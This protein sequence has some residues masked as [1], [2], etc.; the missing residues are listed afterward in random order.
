MTDD[1]KI[2]DGKIRSHGK[3]LTLPAVVRI[4]NAHKRVVQTHQEVLIEANEERDMAL[5]EEFGDWL[6]AQ[7]FTSFHQMTSYG[8]QAV[9]TQFFGQRAGGGEG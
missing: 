3:A 2:I 5:L 9:V 8:R 1:F 6:V 7:R 4:L